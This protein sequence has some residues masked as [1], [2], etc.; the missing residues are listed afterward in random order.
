[1]AVCL[2]LEDLIGSPKYFAAE[3]PVIKS[4]KIKTNNAIKEEL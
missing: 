1:M 2:I 4:I 3:I